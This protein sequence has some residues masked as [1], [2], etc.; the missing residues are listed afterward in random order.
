MNNRERFLTTMKHQEPDRVP[1]LASLTSPLLQ[2][3]RE[4]TGHTSPAEYWDWDLAGVGFRRPDPAPDLMEVYGRYYD[5]LEFEWLLD[6]DK[7]DFPCEWGVATRPAHFFHLSAPLSPMRNFTS[8]AELEAYPLPNYVGDWRHDHLESEVERQKGAGYAVG[9]SVGWIFQT[10]WTLRSEVALFTDFYENPEFA[11]ALLTRITDIRIAQAIRLAE[12]G[13]DSV[14]MN[15]DIGSQKSMIISPAMWRTWIKPRMAALIEAIRAV[16]P[17]I[18]FRYHSDGLLTPVIP[19]LIDIGVSSLRTVQPESMDVFDIKRRFG[20]NIV[21][22][23]TIGLQ[24][25]LSHGTPDDVRE[26]IKAQCEGLKPGG[27]WVASPANGLTPDIPWDNL[28]AMFEA[29]DEH[30]RY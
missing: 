8:L 24:S 30:G 22:E 20:D 2:V 19:E 11:D 17:D 12:A 29:L 27:G 26:M 23:G 9:S 14:S 25:E 4:R 18:L 16:N 5:D 3:F 13:V 6:W 15:D 1:R 28:V 7:S 21:L 10:A